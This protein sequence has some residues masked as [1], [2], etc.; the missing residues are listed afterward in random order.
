MFCWKLINR[1]VSVDQRIMES[2][3]HLASCCACCKY[4]QSE[5]LNHLFL[6]GDLEVS[7]WQWLLP[8]VPPNVHI[9]GSIT[10][11]I[12]YFITKSS[13]SSPLGF[14]S[15]HC[16]IVM[17]WE[18]WKGRCL[19]RF[20]NKN[21]SRKI[22]I[23]N[24]KSSVAHS[25]SKLHFSVKAI[26]KEISILQQL[27]FFPHCRVKQCKF[28]RWIP[29]ILDFSLNVDGAGKGNPGDCGGGGCIRD[30]HGSV[31]IAFSHF[32][33]YGSSMLAEARALCDGLRL[34]D[35]FGIRLSMIN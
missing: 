20:E 13:T 3:I 2:G 24:I 5:D 16:F 17:L 28:I 11:T 26:P 34:A 25:L 1:A 8:L 23:N 35:F 29:P 7:L 9:Q 19:A 30:K 27:G 31:V 33:G 6:L 21:I 12:W 15:L 14:V 18:I 22:I 10:A 32:Y 4:P